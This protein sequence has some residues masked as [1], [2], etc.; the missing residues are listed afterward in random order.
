M[1]E[2]LRAAL[3]LCEMEQTEPGIWRKPL[4]K[5]EAVNDGYVF[6][7]AIMGFPCKGKDVVSEEEAVHLLYCNCL[8][9]SKT[10]RCPCSRCAAVAVA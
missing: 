9:S 6:D 10:E 3:A 2:M 4:R 1:T 7:C 5:L 8:G